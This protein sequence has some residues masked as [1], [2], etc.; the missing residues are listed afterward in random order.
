MEPHDIDTLMDMIEEVHRDY[1]YTIYRNAA[2]NT[3]SQGILAGAFSEGKLP[4]GLYRLLKEA[5][6]NKNDVEYY[7]DRFYPEFDYEYSMGS[8]YWNY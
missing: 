1:P 4:R 7:V 5:D 6:E 8:F 3:I 2:W